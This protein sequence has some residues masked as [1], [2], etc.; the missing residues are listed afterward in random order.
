[1]HSVKARVEHGRRLQLVTRPTLVATDVAAHSAGGTDDGASPP[2]CADC[3]D[4]DERRTVAPAVS[5]RREEGVRRQSKAARK[6]ARRAERL[7]LRRFGV[8]KLTAC[9]LS[10]LVQSTGGE[11]NEEDDRSVDAVAASAMSVD[12]NA[13]PAQPSGHFS[14]T[15]SVKRLLDR[16]T[17]QTVL[18]HGQRHGDRV[19]FGGVTVVQP[20]GG[21][22]VV[23]AWGVPHARE[24]VDIEPHLVGSVIG[25]RGRIIKRIQQRTG[26][27]MT[28]QDGRVYIGPGK[29][30]EA[31]A[32]VSAIGRPMEVTCPSA[33]LPF[34]A[35]FQPQSVHVAISDH[36]D[37]ADTTVR[38]RAWVQ[39]SEPE[40]VDD[41]VQRRDDAV[42]HIRM[43]CQGSVVDF[44]LTDCD[45]AMLRT[46]AT[47]RRL[48]ALLWGAV[49]GRFEGQRAFILFDSQTKADAFRASVAMSGTI[50]AKLVED[51][52]N[53]DG[54][55]AVRVSPALVGCVIGAKGGV[56]K[57]LQRFSCCAIR[58][59]GQGVVVM[60][61]DNASFARQLVEAIAV[62][63][64]VTV[65]GQQL[66]A[67]KKLKRALAALMA[68]WNVRIDTA[69]DD[70]TTTFRV[71]SIVPVLDPQT[72]RFAVERRYE[73]IARLRLL[74]SDGSAEEDEDEDR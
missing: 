43:I 20:L 41:A 38:I 35:A 59:F 55:A 10:T 62:P 66:P 48:L 64:A 42:S 34:V 68:K 33:R 1:M 39:S 5:V 22:T 47:D 57:W 9:R 46:I 4:G 54:V 16:E 45:S 15:R 65:T 3:G 69:R 70:N 25:R 24:I 67:P 31:K 73:A 12:T 60:S 74:M 27:T 36:G 18:K 44:P 72:V 13:V 14:L 2:R 21:T 71:R 51:L 7:H 6:A 49:A 63:F 17:I 8:P 56:L 23:T 52:S 26:C 29:V 37:S 30:S 19:A 61:G 50:G 58:I 53:A 11:E 40:T 32:I 28:V